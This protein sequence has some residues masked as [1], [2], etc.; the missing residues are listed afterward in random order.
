[1]VSICANVLITYHLGIFYLKCMMQVRETQSLN[2]YENSVGTRIHIN[3]LIIQYT[4][5]TRGVFFVL[6][7]VLVYEMG[8]AHDTTALYC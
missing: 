6:V 7:L 4:T 1:M 5:V 8:I 2:V 3:I